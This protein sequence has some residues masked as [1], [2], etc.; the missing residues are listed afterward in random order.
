MV[1]LLLAVLTGVLFSAPLF[2]AWAVESGRGDEHF[3][4]GQ[5][6]IPV[7][8]R[9]QEAADRFLRRE[10]DNAKDKP[11]LHRPLD[12][13]DPVERHACVAW[14]LPA[15]SEPRRSRHVGGWYA[16]GPPVLA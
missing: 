4:A 15:P 13:A 10:D 8:S 9:Q 16:R 14:P 5:H 6:D 3:S 2:T 7:V 12:E 11:V 1:A